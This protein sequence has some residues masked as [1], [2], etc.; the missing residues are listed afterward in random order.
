M[1]AYK[2]LL[3]KITAVEG[4]I[5]VAALCT[6]VAMN[7]IEIIQR[8]LWDISWVWIQELTTTL[9]IW[10]VFM[11]FGKITH[12]KADIYITMFVNK[13]PGRI[14][15]I[16]ALLTNLIIIAYNVAF[17]YYGGLLAEKQMRL[18]LGTIV[19]SIPLWTHTMAAV[20]C[21]CTVL[22]VCAKDIIELFQ[23]NDQKA[24]EAG[25]KGAGL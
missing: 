3:R 11:G 14:Q 21:S 9:F 23:K 7:L 20:V 2:M 16:V 15:K 12:D 8:N 22:L 24:V 1:K 6:M 18:A 19:L 17:I 13:F 4:W 5:A 25:T 10:F